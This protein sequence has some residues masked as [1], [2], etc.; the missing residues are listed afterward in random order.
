MQH[1]ENERKSVL[2]SLFTSLTQH[3]PNNEYHIFKIKTSWA[4]TNNARNNKQADGGGS[5]SCRR[6]ELD[7]ASG[8]T[9]SSQAAQTES[10]CGAPWVHTPQGPD[11]GAAG[12]PTVQVL[13]QRN[14]KGKRGG[15]GASRLK[16]YERHGGKKGRESLLHSDSLCLGWWGK[17]WK[18]TLGTVAQH[19]E[20]INPGKFRVVYILPQFSKISNVIYQ[21][22]SICTL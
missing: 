18:R 19:C 14:W 8:P 10:L 16:N 21:Q 12:G 4:I 1:K 15:V 7:K 20:L 2:A 13:Q 11:S 5:W 6:H 22:P 9:T 17:C 3:L